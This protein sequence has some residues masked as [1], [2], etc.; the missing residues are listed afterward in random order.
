MTA[1]PYALWSDAPTPTLLASRDRST[2][3]RVFPAFAPASPLADQY[4]T[5]PVAGTG[6]LYSFTVIHPN[7]KGGEQPY[8][9]G[10]VD[11]PG[12]VRL[13]GR[14]EGT[15]RPAIG[16]HYMPRP[17]EALGYVFVAQAA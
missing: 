6:T 4:D 1:L 13:F 17:D 8:A 3:E 14:L 16:A 7:P 11:F 9:L 2:Q 10:L 12:P 15:G 5:V